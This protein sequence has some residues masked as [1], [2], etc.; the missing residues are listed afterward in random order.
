METSG[1]SQRLPGACTKVTKLIPLCPGCNRSWWNQTQSLISAAAAALKRLCESPCFKQ[2]PLTSVLANTRMSMWIKRKV[3]G[4]ESERRR[5]G[6][7]QGSR[8]R[9]KRTGAA[10]DQWPRLR[11]NGF[12]I[13]TTLFIIGWV[14]VCS[15]TPP[16]SFLVERWWS[17]WRNAFPFRRWHTRTRTHTHREREEH[18]AQSLLRQTT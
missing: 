13:I 3:C 2:A 10:F 16:L 5:S 14:S 6:S 7:S 8:W 11:R 17:I 18:H 1:Q 15:L 4:N 9:I 12:R